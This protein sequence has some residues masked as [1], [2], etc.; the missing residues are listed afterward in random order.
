MT[1]EL[2]VECPACPLPGVN[3]PEGWNAVDDEERYIA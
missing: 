2:A 3:L 1:G